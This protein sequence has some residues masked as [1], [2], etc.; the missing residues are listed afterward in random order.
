MKYISTMNLNLFD[1]NH[2]YDTNHSIFYKLV[3]HYFEL[4]V[5]VE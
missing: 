5:A 4:K 3:Y 2:Q 1:A